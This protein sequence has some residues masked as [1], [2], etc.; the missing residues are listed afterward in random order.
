MEVIAQLENTPSGGSKILSLAYTDEAGA[1]MIPT[2]IT[3][4]LYDDNG[5]VVNSRSAVVV[6]PASTVSIAL[7]AADC[8]ALVSPTRRR[9]VV[10][11]TYTSV[12]G[13]GIPLVYCGEFFVVPVK[14]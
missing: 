1:S 6:S 7:I 10:T 2:G 5:A 11:A 13:V 4:S 9:I 8:T 14:T 3:W 12:Y